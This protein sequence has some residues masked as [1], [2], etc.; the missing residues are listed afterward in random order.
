MKKYIL[1]LLISG[2]AIAGY[3]GGGGTTSSSSLTS[4][5]GITDGGTGQTSANAAI[6]ALL[7]PQGGN[8]GKFLTTNATDSSWGTPSGVTLSAIGSSANANGATLT[9]SALNLEPASASFGGVVTTGTQ[10]FAGA[11]TFSSALS[12][13]LGTVGAPGLYPGTDT[14]TGVYSPGAD[15]I[16]LAAGGANKF[17][18]DALG[19]VRI[20]SSGNNSLGHSATFSLS[21]GGAG[22]AGLAISRGTYDTSM[23]GGVYYTATSPNGGTQNIGFRAGMDGGT[24]NSYG[25]GMY[26]ENNVTNSST[27]SFAP[28]NASG[29]N[30]GARFDVTV[31]N[32]T[33]QAMGVAA[34][35]G[36]GKL[37]AGGV[38]QGIQPR[39][40]SGNR[41]EGVRAHAAR[42]SA[43]MSFPTQLVGVYGFITNTNSAAVEQ[44]NAGVSSAAV[45]DNVDTSANIIY[46]MADGGS[47]FNVKS[48]GVTVMQSYSAVPVTVDLTADNQTVT[49]TLSSIRLTSDN[50]TATDR[51]FVLA[52]GVQDGQH[53]TLE[54][55]EDNTTGAGE[56]ADSGNQNL[57]AIWSPNIG[58]TITLIW[59]SGAS[60][61]RELSRS[62][63]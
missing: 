4:P 52:D 38:F 49:G 56:M 50:F 42:T 15:Q 23:P 46:G 10:T 13:P 8:S 33:G 1:A 3:Y 59:N 2:V 7:P 60:E 40:V 48:T 17:I 51:T 27:S 34:T 45:F 55:N 53:L 21:G 58:D 29:G 37:N 25:F 32:D 20:V 12:I 61:W 44:R 63:N 9:G 43:A 31:A 47:V 19:G 24:I 28:Y 35:G 57:S 16:A 36:Q 62:D 22:A 41:A 11:K 18:S 5:V 26:I 30:V 14:D 6:N 54:W 39:D